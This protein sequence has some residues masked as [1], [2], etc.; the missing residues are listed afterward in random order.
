MCFKDPAD[1][2]CRECPTCSA[3]GDPVCYE[4]H[5]L[6]LT[7]EQAISRQWVRIRELEMQIADENQYLIYLKEGGDFDDELH[8]EA[9]V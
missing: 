9:N 7:R 2:I 5:D 4:K 1:C 3:Q 6:R 8:I